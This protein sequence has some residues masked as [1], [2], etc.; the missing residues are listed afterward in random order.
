MNLLVLDTSTE[1]CAV[2]VAAAGVHY[3]RFELTPRRHTEC[4]LPWSEL[5]L[6]QADRLKA[7][8][9]QIGQARNQTLADTEDTL[10]EIGPGLGALTAPL[11]ARVPKL[12]VVELDR[13]LAARL[14]NTLAGMGELIIHSGDALQFDFA[15]LATS[16]GAS[17]L[18]VIG[19]LPYNISTPLLFH[20]LEHTEVVHDMHFML[21]KE[22][23]DR[24][25][26]EPGSDDYGRLTVSMAARA[27]RSGRA[28]ASMA[29]AAS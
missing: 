3:G 20:L 27:S 15:P 6:A 13:D 10:V 11:I 25:C 26:A 23:V 12:T 18:R 19:N 16:P 28:W 2:G 17:D 8:V 9:F 22:V 1:A 29:R 5:L 14:P 21:Q 7:L 24:M 4:V